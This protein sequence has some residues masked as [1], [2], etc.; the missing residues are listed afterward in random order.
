MTRPPV[1]EAV[2]GSMPRLKGDLA[3]LVGIPSVS[4]PGYPESTHGPLLEAYEAVAE[5]FRDAGVGDVRPLELPGTAPIVTGEIPAPDGA[6]TVLLYSHYDVVPAG[7]EALWVSPPFEATERDGA[8]YGRGTADTKANILAHVGAL[9][10]W[11][12]KPPIGTK[13]FT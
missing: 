2:E 8:I 9:R 3:R 13:V 12:G 10:A 1:R 4:A 6:P 5:L 11:G 7:D